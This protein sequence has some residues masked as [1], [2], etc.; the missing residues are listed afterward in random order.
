MDFD[1]TFYYQ[2]KIVQVALLL[3]PVVGWIVEILIR[4]SALTKKQCST[5][6]V[7]LIVYILIGWAIIPTFIDAIYIIPAD[8]V[9]CCVS[10]NEE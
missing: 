9:I 6:V 10:D 7:G 1:E 4:I 5:N 3:I 2:L 8:K